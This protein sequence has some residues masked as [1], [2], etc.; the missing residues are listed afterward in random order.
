MRYRHRHGASVTARRRGEWRSRR[1]WTGGRRWRTGSRPRRRRC[2]SSSRGRPSGWD[3]DNDV[4]AIPLSPPDEDGYCSFGNSVFFAPTL[5]ATSKHLVGEIHPDFIRT[6]GQN[7][8][9]ISK[10]DRVTL[11]EGQ[12][13]PAPIAP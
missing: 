4:A 8:V 7:R 5:M 9:H 12:A 13:A 2:E 1:R 3:F 11:F 6:G 10:F